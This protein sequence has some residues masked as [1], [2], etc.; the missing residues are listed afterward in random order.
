MISCR[1]IILIGAATLLLSETI[2][3]QRSP[4]AGARPSGYKDRLQLQPTSGTQA[5]ASPSNSDIGNRFGEGSSTERLPYDAYGDA[6]AFQHGLQLPEANRPFWILNQAH[7]EAQRGTPSTGANVNLTTRPQ[8]AANA[9]ANSSQIDSAN[10]VVI[11]PKFGN[12]AVVNSGQNSL[13]QNENKQTDQDIVYPSNITPEQRNQMEQFVLQQNQRAIQLQRNQLQQ[14]Q[15]QQ[16]PLVDRVP[17]AQQQAQT[18]QPVDQSQLRQQ[19]FSADQGRT[20]IGQQPNQNQLIPLN[21]QQIDNRSNRMR[22]FSL[23][24]GLNQNLQAPTR[25]VF[26]PTL[27][28]S[29]Q[30]LDGHSNQFRSL[31]HYPDYFGFIPELNDPFPL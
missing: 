16:N 5:Q 21:N 2:T 23:H 7:I 19:R 9:T 26:E 8:T 15:L 17:A 29:N 6:A 10:N 1:N 30:Q 27:P 14:N 31:R 28:L 18:I 3:A 25:P 4:Y 12:G 11:A 13:D 20:Q 24:Q 22:Q